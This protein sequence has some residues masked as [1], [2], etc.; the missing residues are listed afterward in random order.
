MGLGRKLTKAGSRQLLGV[1]NSRRWIGP[2]TLVQHAHPVLRNS[3]PR[4]PQTPWPFS[5]HLAELPSDRAHSGRR[6]LT[7]YA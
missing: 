1:S 6:P 7:P 5:S 3:D 2:D 4:T